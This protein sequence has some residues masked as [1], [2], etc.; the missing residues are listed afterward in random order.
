MWLRAKV[1]PS[2]LSKEIDEALTSKTLP[3]HLAQAVDAI[4]AVGNFGA[5][6]LKS[7]NSSE[8]LDLEPGEAELLLDVLEGLFDFY[9]VQPA[10]MKKKL[11]GVNKKLT[12]AGKPPL[13]QPPP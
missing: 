10:V 12:E 7:T 4:R 6:P 2:D 5:H 13:K 3:S 11:E 9:F 8:V 1:K